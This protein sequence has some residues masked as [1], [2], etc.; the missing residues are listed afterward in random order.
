[1]RT[2]LGAI[3]LALLL[4]CGANAEQKFFNN[5]LTLPDLKGFE[6]LPQ[7]TG[8]KLPKKA[9]GY[10]KRWKIDGKPD[11][12][13]KRYLLG[14]ADKN[15]WVTVSLHH[16]DYGPRASL[17]PAKFNDQLKGMRGK[18][19]VTVEEFKEVD[20]KGLGKIGAFSIK[21]NLLKGYKTILLFIPAVKEGPYPGNNSAFSVGVTFDTNNA[22]LAKR[23]IKTIIAQGKVGAK[24]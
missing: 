22:P 3:F 15:L 16:S 10:S 2:V 17:T 6:L 4:F 1:M 14:R 19:G 7:S 21:P 5:R 11:L 24:K 18:S 9:D 13:A 20:T 23:I 12:K 8:F